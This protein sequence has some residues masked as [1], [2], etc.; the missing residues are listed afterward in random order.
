MRIT[1]GCG[2]QEGQ[3]STGIGRPIYRE[4]V[5]KLGRNLGQTWEKNLRLLCKSGPRFTCHLALFCCISINSATLYVGRRPQLRRMFAYDDFQGCFGKR[6]VKT[7]GVYP[8]KPIK[9]AF[10][11]TP[12]PC[13]PLCLPSLPITPSPP[14]LPFHS[15]PSA[16]GPLKSSW[17]VRCKFP[18]RGLER[19]SR[20][21]QIWCILA[22]KCNSWWQ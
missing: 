7:R 14:S 13:S 12:F 15:L 2:L 10:S 20:R 22:L 11:L 19:S 18:R 21:S 16:V 4:S 9:Q 17:E 8:L 5:D 1:V 3:C 6:R